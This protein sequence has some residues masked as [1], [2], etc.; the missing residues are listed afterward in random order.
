MS[1]FGEA[2]GTDPQG[3]KRK[4]T[5]GTFDVNARRLVTAGEDG[6]VKIWNFS[7]GHALK[8]LVTEPLKDKSIKAK[9][10]T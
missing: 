2:H 1:R 6:S 10:P 7:N 4:V 9:P 3:K 5:C 8:N